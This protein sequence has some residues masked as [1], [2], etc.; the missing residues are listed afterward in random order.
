MKNNVAEIAGNLGP[1]NT[2]PQIAR[3]RRWF[4]TVVNIKDDTKSLES[5]ISLY[6]REWIYGKETAPSTGMKHLHFF[7]R[8]KNER[9]WAVVK[10]DL[11]WVSDLKMITGKTENDKFPIEYCRKE[12]RGGYVTNM[13][14]YKRVKSPLDGKVLYPYQQ[15]VISLISNPIDDRKIYWYWEPTG[16]TGK[17]ALVKHICLNYP[18]T[19]AVGGKA[20]DIKYAVQ[21]LDEKPTTILIDIPRA[22]RND[23]AFGAIEEVKNGCFFSGKYESGMVLMDVPNIII[24]SN[25][26]PE[27]ENLSMDRWVIKRI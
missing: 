20:Q 9:T 18:G 23:M 22:Y 27:T 24:F 12:D 10:A 11:P 14:K 3:S 8:L 15:E 2:K 21:Q 4:G 1:P 7:G 5:L 13:P 16:N 25:F 19:L 17:S 6:F 26:E